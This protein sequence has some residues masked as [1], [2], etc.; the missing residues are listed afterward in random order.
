[1]MFSINNISLFNN[2]V[3]R[4]LAM[5]KKY[6]R[7]NEVYWYIF[8]CVAS[9]VFLSVFSTYTSPFTKMQGDDAAFFRLVGQGMT[10]GMLPYRDFF[11]MK[12][13][14]MF[15]IEY[16]SQLICF[17]RMGCFVYQLM[18]LTVIFCVLDKIH[19]VTGI[20]L[21]YTHRF[22][23]LLPYSWI[24]AATFEGGN[25]TEEFSLPFLLICLYCGVRYFTNPNL[26]T[27]PAFYAFIYGI[28][29]GV[30]SLI[31]I[32]NA[33]TICAL[34]LGILITLILKKSYKNIWH[35]ALAFLCGSF[36][37]I[38][39][40][41]VYCIYNGIL[42]EMVEAVFLF[43][44]TYAKEGGLI[45]WFF[46]DPAKLIFVLPMLLP[47]V[48]TF[49]TSYKNNAI[50]WLILLDTIC[51]AVVVSM[52]N[53]YPHYFTL[54][55]PHL[56]FGFVMVAHDIGCEN[57]RRKTVRN[58]ACIVCICLLSLSWMILLRCGYF[59]ISALT[60]RWVDYDAIAIAER[61]PEEDHSSVYTY[62]VRSHWY[63]ETGLY[64]CIKYCDWQDH[65]IALNPNIEEE[66][67]MIFSADPPK[68]IITE[69]E[70]HPAFLNTVLT[71]QYHLFE[72]N[73]SYHLW[74]S[75]H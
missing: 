16:I 38:T 41:V 64:P 33:V 14:Y 52:G 32:T 27:H 61:I 55:I 73:D 4:K 18:N 19:M 35:N 69:N 40:A 20:N 15:L 60:D 56:A 48:I 3:E 28:C 11:D 25:L 71:R 49:V 8:L 53:C 62:G 7:A 72:H 42:I 23:L 26:Q 63:T 24:M 68:W 36:F 47:I 21:K 34:I 30:I 58:Y 59:I 12:G 67:V 46:K 50:K 10:K 2:F 6:G 13:P 37:A 54:V 1:M 70:E 66:L 31:R 51:L 39:P 22:F 75:S 5:I 43:G 9:F 45:N 74:L 65:Y 29:F 44:F 17:G 57:Q